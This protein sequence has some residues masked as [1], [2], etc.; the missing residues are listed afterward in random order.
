M[1]GDRG[2]GSGRSI[3]G[4]DLHQALVACEEYLEGYGGH[5]M[6]GGLRIRSARIPDFT[7]AFRD[8]ANRK[9][10]AQDLTAKLRLD[11]EVHLSELSE[12]HVQMLLGLGPFGVDNPRPR[13]CTKLLPLSGEPRVVGKTQEHLQ[14]AV[15]DE[16]TVLRAIAFRHAD[17]ADRLLEH[18]TCRLACEPIIN[19]FRGRR[20]VELNVL[21]IQFPGDEP[22]AY[23]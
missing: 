20:N 2:Q 7:R 16:G 11:A 14:L 5:A 23:V 3:P 12:P 6:A 8:Y 4:F 1:D 19:E 15:S 13:F 17:K 10:T 9:L 22:P 21:D 18:R